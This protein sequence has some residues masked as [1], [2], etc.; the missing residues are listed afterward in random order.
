M[1]KSQAIQDPRTELDTFDPMDTLSTHNIM[2]GTN[3]GQQCR[4]ASGQDT[5][6]PSDTSGPRVWIHTT[7]QIHPSIGILG[8][9]DTVV[10]H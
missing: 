5:H 2:Q 10:L 4:A 7:L 9:H 1:E 8:P 3:A 6:K